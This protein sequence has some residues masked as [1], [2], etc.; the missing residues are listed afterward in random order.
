M[1]SAPRAATTPANVPVELTLTATRDH[2]DPFNT[3][4]V[5]VTFTDPQGRSFCVPAFW[6]GGRAWK[7]RYAS[8]V[9]GSHGWSS[10]SSAADD[11]GLHGR[12]G[13]VAVTPYTGDN[14]LFR[15]GPPQVSGDRRFLQHADG[16]PFFWLGDT[17][18]MGLCTRL[19]WPDGFQKIAADRKKK[20]FTVVQIVAGLYPDMPAFDPRGANEAGFPWTEEYGSIRPEYYDAADT[21]LR[22]LV[23]QGIAPCLVGAWGY[24]I[25]WMGAD[26]LKQHWR[27]LIGRYAAWPMTWC[28]AG[29]A[30]LPW[31]LAKNFPS[32]DRSQ[33]HEWTKVIRY[34]R[35]TDPFRRPLTIHPTAINRYTARNATEDSSLLDFDLLQTPHAQNEGVPITVK[36]MRDSYDD[37][38]TLPVIDGEPCYEML[39]DSLITAWPRRAFWTCLM[40]GACGHTYGANG[41]WQCNQPG[42]PHGNSPWGGGYGKITWEESMN[43]PGSSHVALGK[44][45]LTQYPWPRFRPHPEWAAF[46]E[47]RWLPLDGAKWIWDQPE[48]PAPDAPNRRVYFRRSFE[49]PAGRTVTRAHLRFAGVNHIESR[50]NNTPTGTGWDR[51]TG[52]QFDDLAR[53]IRSG[54]NVLTIWDEHRPV[55]KDPVGLL[56]C[57]ELTFDDGSVQRLVTDRNWKCATKEVEGWLETGF[58]DQSWAHA[59]ELGALGSEPWGAITEPDPEFFGPLS[60]GIPGLVRI[61][62]IPCALPVAVRHLGPDSHYAATYFNPLSG[63]RTPAAAVRPSAAGEWLCAA[64]RGIDHDWVL[65]LEASN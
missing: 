16:T 23:D 10:E 47:L 44:Q 24:F 34:V 49:V 60:A 52:A 28:V 46:P 45:L 65:I 38:L 40:S 13:T 27:Y 4:I 25:P 21:K 22:H 36:A 43:L 41:I 39:G 37:P 9:T 48:S 61:H 55:T 18:W 42:Q 64:P 62:Y 63:E 57:L 20:G 56:G 59:A 32:D 2:A 29:E 1:S 58:D 26:K 11:T 12:K 15:H 50:I 14:P 35:E 8:P 54:T 6:A 53:H 51:R 30:N 3:V 19:P 7:V 17:W 33:V 31:Y 5:D